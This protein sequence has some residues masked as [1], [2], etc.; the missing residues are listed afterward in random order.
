MLTDRL[1]RLEHL[2]FITRRAYPT[3]PPKV[4]YSL[5]ELGESFTRAHLPV[6]DWARSNL[7]YVNL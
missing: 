7:E 6:I 3:I 4:E 2:G 5:T 1:H